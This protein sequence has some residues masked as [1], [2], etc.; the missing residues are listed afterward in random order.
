MRKWKSKQAKAL[1]DAYPKHVYPTRAET[2]IIALLKS[3]ELDYDVFMHRVQAQHKIWKHGIG[4][5]SG[6]QF[7]PA[8]DQWLLK[9]GYDNEDVLDECSPNKRL[10]SMFEK[11]KQGL[12]TTGG[13]DYLELR[14]VWLHLRKLD[15]AIPCDLFEVAGNDYNWSVFHYGSIYAGEASQDIMSAIERL[16]NA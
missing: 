6:L 8:M 1:Y 5:P 4:V 14:Y 13:M 12:E 15:R 7:C 16:K 2:R 9:G 10:K 3:G 11:W